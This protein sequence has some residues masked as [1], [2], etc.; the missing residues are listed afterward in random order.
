MIGSSVVSIELL[1]YSL[2]YTNAGLLRTEEL[3]MQA[4]YNRVFLHL[5]LHG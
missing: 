1:E 4:K 5:V 2:N 3:N